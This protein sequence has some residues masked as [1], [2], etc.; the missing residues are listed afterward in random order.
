[1]YPLKWASRRLDSLLAL[2]LA[3]VVAV[4]GLLDR[5]SPAT[6]TSATLAVL[7]VLAISVLRTYGEREQTIERVSE[8]ISHIRQSSADE[9]FAVHQADIE[10]IAEARSSVCMVQETGS[11]ITENARHQLVALLR[12][13]GSVRVVA[14]AAESTSAE[15]LA[16]R[17]ANLQ[18]RDISRRHK[19]FRGHLQNFS[20]QAGEDARRLE[21]RWIPYPVDSTYVLVDSSAPDPAN[22]QG[23]VRLAGFLVPY[24]QKLAL[25]FDGSRSPH[26]LSHYRD[27]FE[28]YFLAAS[29]VIL[30]EGAPRIGKT[31]L[32]T[33]ML[34]SVAESD[35]F[36]ALSVEQESPRRGPKDR[37]T[38]FSLRCADRL[39]DVPFASRRGPQDYAVEHGP[40]VDL[41]PRLSVAH[42]AGRV[43][44]L[45]EIGLLQSGVPGFL[46]A[47]KQ[48]MDDPRATLFASIGRNSAV[49]DA[50]K[51]H[52][53]ATVLSLTE[54]TRASVEERLM[55]EYRASVACSHARRRVEP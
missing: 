46:D 34:Q 18:T 3:M 28:R 39:E 13:G 8:M 14:A 47:V 53:R 6:A 52:P 42:K 45:D 41:L 4:L 10:L 54:E 50:F 25:N 20:E 9:L 27:E 7:G 17:N 21:V 24:P 30:I 5:V 35:A 43:L 15:M 22:R 1:M 31:T 2:G 12:N 11:L 55:A 26:T 48:V 29:K 33:R 51:R 49:L 16:F 37:R 38:G 32:L 44:V 23:A 40:W 36:W 19:A